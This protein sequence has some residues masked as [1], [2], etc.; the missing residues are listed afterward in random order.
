MRDANRFKVFF[1]SIKGKIFT[2]FLVA[3]L[4]ASGLTLLNVWTLSAMRER[5]VLSE[6]YD[7]FLNAILEA[8]RFE[9]NLFIYGEKENYRD[10][11]AYLDQAATALAELGGDIVRISDAGD[12]ANIQETLTRYRQEFSALE[13]ARLSGMDVARGT[14]KQLVDL[15]SDLIATKRERIHR[16]IV[17]V[18]LLPCA[19]LGIFLVFM[20]FLIKVINHSLLRPLGLVGQITARV[21]TGDFSPVRHGGHHIVEIAG[22]LDALDRMALELAAHQEDLL[23]ARKIA[24]LGT[25]TAGIAHEINN[26]INNIMLSA[27]SMI[28][29]HGQDLDEDGREIV[30]DIL[31]QAE[32]AGEIVRNLLDFSR[33]EKARFSPLSPEVIVES[34][35][36]LVKNQIMISGLTVGVDVPPGLPGVVGNLRHL[37]Q[38]FVNLLQNAVHATA[39]GGRIDILAREEPNSV[40][41]EVRDTGKGIDKALLPHIFEPFFTTKDVGKGT[42]LG[43][44]VTYSIIKRHSGRIEVE[45]EPG[46]GTTFIIHLPRT[47]APADKEESEHAV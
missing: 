15:A 38:V 17:V 16:T 30:S 35:L 25:L 6:R 12:L 13:S 9:K 3:F 41:L 18:S 24:A 10:G 5:L 4:A 14:G 7:D 47:A 31:S 2:L 43:L 33:T 45:S 11:M 20:A 39:P 32:R 34:S 8:R 19:Y 28:E 23:Q 21:A 37:Q 42:G 46:L 26:P 1:N 40:R 27:E 36:A 22:L 29:I 44:A